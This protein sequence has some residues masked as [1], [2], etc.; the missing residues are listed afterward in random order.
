MGGRVERRQHGQKGTD[1]RSPRSPTRSRT[2]WPAAKEVYVGERSGPY[3][4]STTLSVRGGGGGRC[5]AAR[6]RG[7]VRC[8]FGFCGSG[9]GVALVAPALVGSAPVRR[10]GAVRGR[11]RGWVRVCACWSRFGVGRCGVAGLW[12]CVRVLSGAGLR[13]FGLSFALFGGGCAPPFFFSLCGGAARRG[14]LRRA[15]WSL[16]APRPQAAPWVCA[17]AFSA[18]LRPCAGAR[19]GPCSV[20]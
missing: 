16:L 12:L 7:V 19:W 14:P 6:V 2:S 4:V 1:V 13:G 5:G 15:A 20:L 17:L 9:S 3:S 11:R 8:A 18:S 10:L